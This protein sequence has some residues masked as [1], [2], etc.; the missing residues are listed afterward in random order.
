[1]RI[2]ILTSET[3]GLPSRCVEA[4]TRST[5][6]EISCVI[7]ARESLLSSGGRVLRRKLRKVQ[8]IGLAATFNA[9]R[10]R[11]W[12]RV[13][14]AP[15]IF[16]ICR[17]RSLPV[18]SVDRLN[19]AET[20]AAL[21]AHDVDLA[22]AAGTVFIG[23]KLRSAPKLGVINIHLD[24]LPEYKNGRSVIWN[25]YNGELTTGVSI[26][27]VTEE[28]DG[29]PL[30]HRVTIPIALQR[31]LPETVRT[32]VQDLHEAA[33]PAL[34]HVI[35]NYDRLPPFPQEGGARYGAPSLREFRR[36]R[37]NHRELYRFSRG[38]PRSTARRSSQ[39]IGEKRL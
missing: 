10:M 7:H 39:S 34:V 35:R 37:A 27:C 14:R 18:I 22:V 32:T 33:G 6:V 19:S 5:D 17:Q 13:P 26:H 30:L 25:L 11:G 20:L 8:T 1:M 29:G 12:F 24:K 4:L 36:I 21:S 16:E 38:N 2:A 9:L 15:C 28:I 3:S 31:T 23:P